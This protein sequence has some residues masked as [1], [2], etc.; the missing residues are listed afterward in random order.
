LI[1][2]E[3]A[4]VTHWIWGWM[5]PRAILDT[6]VKRK[7]PSPRRESNPR[8]LIVQPVSL[9]AIPK[10]L[11]RL[12]ESNR[13]LHNELCIWTLYQILR[14]INLWYGGIILKRIFKNR[15]WECGL[16]IHGSGWGPLAG[17]WEYGKESWDSIKREQFSDQLND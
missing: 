8:T 7:I 5:G 17:S 6:V 11:S 13:K 1:P 3:S 9:V 14:A 10:E 2:R 15:V 12:L 16:I 4:P